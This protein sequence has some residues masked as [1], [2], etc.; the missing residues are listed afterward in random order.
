[1][2]HYAVMSELH[3]PYWEKREFCAVMKLF[4]ASNL[5]RSGASG[6]GAVDGNFDVGISTTDALV[7]VRVKAE[8][9]SVQVRHVTAHGTALTGLRMQDSQDH[10]AAV[11]GGSGVDEVIVMLTG[12]RPQDDAVRMR[13]VARQFLDEQYRERFIQRNQKYGLVYIDPE[14]GQTLCCY[15]FA[16]RLEEVVEVNSPATIQRIFNRWAAGFPAG[17]RFLNTNLESLCLSAPVAGRA[18]TVREPVI[19]RA[20]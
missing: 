20:S 6:R 12:L 5:S 11:L 10:L 14:D 18:Y 8:G 13:W 15:K 2:F 17:M 9:D 16:R 1:M 7:H 4:R 3:V 19:L